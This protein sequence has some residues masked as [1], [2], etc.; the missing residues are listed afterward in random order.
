MR[1]AS[2]VPARRTA[3][4]A[5]AAALLA[6]PAALPAGAE[7]APAPNAGLHT[8]ASCDDLVSYVRA[9]APRLARE[10]GFST[11]YARGEPIAQVGAED[12]AAAS[13][14]TPST[15]DHSETNNQEAGVDEPDVV[16]TD[17]QRMFVLD[18]G[19]SLRVLDV[20]GDKP[21]LVTTFALPS[22]W[23]SGMLLEG[24]RL[25]VLGEPATPVRGGQ[26]APDAP[27]NM[28][29]SGTQAILLDVKDLAAPRI[30]E[31]YVVSGWMLGAR[32][33]GTTVRLVTDDEPNLALRV[34]ALPARATSVRQVRAAWRKALRASTQTAWLPRMR[35]HR[36]HRTTL[37]GAA[38]GC[39]DVSRPSEYSG[40]GTV[41]V[42]TFDVEAGLT[43]V[44]T[45]SILA[46][47][48]T[49][50]ASPT[51]LYVA[52]ARQL[53]PSWYSS[54]APPPPVDT[55]VHRFDTSSPTSTTYAGSG[56]VRGTV[57]NQFAMSELDGVLRIAT[58]E[59]PPWWTGE[60]PEGTRSQ[61]FVTTLQLRDGRLEQLG[62]LGGLGTDERIYATRFIGDRAYVVTFRQVDPLHVVDLSD[63]AHPTLRGELHIAGYSAYLHP[64]GDHLLLGI[65]QDANEEGRVKGTQVSLFD[66]SDPDAPRRLSVLQLPGGW[67]DAEWDHHA[68]LWWDATALGVMPVSL[69]PAEGDNDG[70][71]FVGALAVR[72]TAEGGVREIGRIANEPIV[73]EQPA[74]P[75]PD[76]GATDGAVSQSMPSPIVR[77]VVVRDALLTISG[78]GV[79]SSSL[80]ALATHTWTP[81]PQVGGGPIG[82]PMPIEPGAGVG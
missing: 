6:G 3:A 73:F 38:V 69:P 30:L 71:G 7:E 32:L 47:G 41:T 51:A 10:Y 24:D 78:S 26:A 56:Q 54:D 37:R 35:H 80:G 67:S 11:G 58:T 34:D 14:A 50:Y 21:R 46:T 82:M 53:D 16:K 36:P 61:S 55:V 18:G 63:P 62:R 75:G 44:D 68:F 4:L 59:L 2:T 74:P 76:A 65:G 39:D 15:P 17:G 22:A 1:I 9:R 45:D 42:T 27:L 5:A 64:V 43:P 20:S 13:P 40:V 33:T 70:Y 57:L 31:R 29:E 8:F 66:V 60:L 72:A 48:G 28:P 77:A 81:F 12:S 79:R 52:T 23:A 25:L 19:S 49:I